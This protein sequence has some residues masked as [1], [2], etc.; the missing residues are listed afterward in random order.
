MEQALSNNE[1]LA[2]ALRLL[3][4]AAKGKKKNC[5]RWYRVNT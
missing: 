3:E 1:K 4:D 5:A 2:E